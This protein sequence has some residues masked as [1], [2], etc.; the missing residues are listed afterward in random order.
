MWTFDSSC[1]GFGVIQ[2][3]TTI[4]D[5]DTPSALLDRQILTANIRR[6]QE[7]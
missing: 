2:S 3:M 4:Y 5:L 7:V 1:S 6:A